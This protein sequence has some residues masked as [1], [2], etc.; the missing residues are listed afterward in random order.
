MYLNAGPIWMKFKDGELRYLHAGGKEIVRRLYF[1]VRD[2]RW[3]TVMPRF[4]NVKVSR[5]PDSFHITF[6]AICKND[7]A[8]YQWHGEITGTPDGRITYSV[9]GKPVADFAT[10]RVGLNVLY[11]AQSLIAQPYEVINKA[12]TVASH[13]FPAGISR[14]LLSPDFLTLRYVTPDGMLFTA[15]LTEGTMGMEDQRNFGDSSHKAFGSLPY[16]YPNIKK[17]DSRTQALIID[18]SNAPAAQPLPQTISVL[19]SDQP[20][21]AA[22]PHFITTDKLPAKTFTT[23][24]GK[25][26]PDTK[27]VTWSFNPA[28]HMPDDDTFMENLTALVDQAN[29]ARSFSPDAKLHIDSI[30]FDSPYPRPHS[31]PRNNTPFAAAWLTIAAKYLSIAALE[32][33]AFNI[34]APYASLAL[35]L[36]NPYAGKPLLQTDISSPL[37]N[38]I[39]AWAVQDATAPAVFLINKTRRRQTVALKIKSAPTSY[40]LSRI[41]PDAKITEEPITPKNNQ[42]TITLNPLETSRLTPPN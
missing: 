32:D 10:P 4:H 8:D 16:T 15:T 27:D 26:S 35:S 7:I 28:L 33:A 1:G 30:G 14:D 31:D 2:S 9:T 13:V 34:P 23:I 40:T 22:V 12:G 42:I 21:N 39:D 3:D 38:L 41:Q 37:P 17:D 25:I 6:N 29:T 19:V 11:P 36:L 24:Q 18:V 5:K 20:I